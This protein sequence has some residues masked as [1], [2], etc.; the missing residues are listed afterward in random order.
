MTHARSVLRSWKRR[1]T[2]CLPHAHLQ[3]SS[4]TVLVW[5]W[6]TCRKKWTGPY[7]APYVDHL[8]SNTLVHLVHWMLWKHR[9]DVVFS[10][11][12]P[13]SNRVV[14]SSRDSAHLWKHRLSWLNAN[15]A[16]YI[17]NWAAKLFCCS[18]SIEGGECSSRFPRKR[19]V[20]LLATSCYLLVWG[21]DV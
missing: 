1:L 16:T 20:F 18:Y 19:I 15:N 13:S 17:C 12:L 11:M 10:D 4:G 9:N 14:A 8:H 5:T 7:A 6:I 2:W 3:T 21:L